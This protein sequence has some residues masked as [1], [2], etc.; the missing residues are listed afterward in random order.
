[1]MAPSRGTECDQ[2]A[3]AVWW[4]NPAV[5]LWVIRSMVERERAQTASKGPKI[6]A[7]WKRMWG[8]TDS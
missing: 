8:R 3:N 6:L 1:M 5:R 4:L 2:T 7:K